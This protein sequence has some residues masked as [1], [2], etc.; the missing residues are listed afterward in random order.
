MTS[1]TQP[2]FEGPSS[3]SGGK[4]VGRRGASKVGNVTVLQR[5]EI[6]S[7]EAAPTLHRHLDA[8]QVVNRCQRVLR[9]HDHIGQFPG[10]EAAH[11]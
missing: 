11:F 1:F 6:L 4:P 3:I 7:C 9:E 8:L 10:F 2:N 5:Y